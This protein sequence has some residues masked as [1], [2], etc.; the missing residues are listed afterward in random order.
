MSAIQHD[1]FIKLK[2]SSLDSS[3]RQLELGIKYLAEHPG[4][5]YFGASCLAFNVDRHKQ[6]PYL[7]NELDFDVAFHMIFKDAQS[8]DMYQVSDRHVKHFI[9]ESKG[10]WSKIRVFDSKIVKQI[11]AD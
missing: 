10:N 1:I 7:V 6:V 9:P 5:L 8:H 4:Q 3:K 11:Y 2:D